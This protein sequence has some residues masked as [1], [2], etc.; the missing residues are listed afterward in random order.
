MKEN[1]ENSKFLKILESFNIILYDEYIFSNIDKEI[2]FLS[3]IEKLKKNKI[4]LKF[5][6]SDLIELI[7]NIEINNNTIEILEKFNWKDLGE[8][9][10]KKNLTPRDKKIYEGFIDF[11]KIELKIFFQ[12][13]IKT[14]RTLI[15]EEPKLRKKSFIDIDI[16]KKQE[17]FD[18]IADRNRK[19]KEYNVNILFDYTKKSHNLKVSD[20]TLYFIKR[21]EYFTNLIEKRLNVENLVSINQLKKPENGFEDIGSLY[22]S[23]AQ[24]TIIGLINEIRETKNGYMIE[25]E[26]KTSFINCFVNKNKL[27]L[28]KKVEE[29]CLDEGIGVVGKSGEGIVWVENFIVPSSPNNSELKKTINENYI[30]F[31]SDIHM[32]ANVFVDSAFSKC[33]DILSGNVK[34]GQ[35]KEIQKKL[36]YIFIAGDLIE[37]IGVYP[38]QGKDARLLSTNLQYNEIA[39]WLS[40]I[41]KDICIIIVPGNHDTERLSEP[42]PKLSYD[43]AYAL[44][45]LPNVIILSNPSIVR[46]FENDGNDN[47]GLDF[48]IY[49][50][51]SLFYYADKIKQLRERGGAKTPE[52][53]VEY[54]LDKKHLAPSHGSTLYI[55]DSNNDPLVIKKIPDFFVYGHTHKWSFVN[56]K[57]CS[58]ISCGCWVEMSDYQEKMGM[59]PDIGKLVLVNSKTRKPI[60]FNLYEEKYK[61]EKKC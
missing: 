38:N 26:D 49:H 17:N 53:V 20:F 14:D 55:P 23:N 21:L 24:V 22:G 12:E 29:F 40:Q 32:G 27:E 42:Q 1:N 35:I 18:V 59:Y 37:G 13:E 7:E 34:G 50:G 8:I 25:I 2:K 6:N 10:K 58:L 39:K 33:I 5:L 28:I 57:G 47:G 19:A 9:L 36:K 31:L 30:A 48:H 11:L 44:Y 16:F 41:P 54:L 45:N 61:R 15:D 46:L 43:K 52:F 3:K 51:G 56:Y 60:L 4:N